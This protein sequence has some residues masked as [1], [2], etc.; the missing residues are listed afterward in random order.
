MAKKNLINADMLLATPKRQEEYRQFVEIPV[1]VVQPPVQPL[2]S[3]PPQAEVS[4]I[5]KGLKHDETR[6]TF[7]VREDLLEK[8]KAVAY[9]ERLNIKEVINEALDRYVGAYERQNG[10]LKEVPKNKKL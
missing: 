6:A 4:S 7:I 9:W 8:L 2:P 1:P 10:D 5:K 3:I